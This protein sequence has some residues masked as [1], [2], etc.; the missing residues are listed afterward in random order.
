MEI[1][2]L[3]RV[4]Y[5]LA[6]E[7]LQQ[8]ELPYTDLDQDQ[9]QLFSVHENE[10]FVGV[11]GF[12]KY[13]EDALLRSVAIL[14]EKQQLGRGG[15][16]IQLIENKAKEVRIE[17]FYLLTTTAAGFFDKK[18]YR[19]IDRINAPEALQQTTEFS[20]LCPDSAICM[21]KTLL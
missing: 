20:T 1:R 8:L 19:R 5:D 12:E 11:G 3:L 2:K 7:L 18:G 10:E 21:M 14:P 16:I 17:R 13:G 4:E 15:Q 6:R 9:L